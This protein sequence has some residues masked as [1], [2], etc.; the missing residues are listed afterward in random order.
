MYVEILQRRYGTSEDTPLVRIAGEAEDKPPVLIAGEYASVRAACEQN[1]SKLAHADLRGA[2][3]REANLYQAYMPQ[4]DLSGADLACANL[5]CAVLNGATLKDAKLVSASMHYTTA[6]AAELQ[7]ADMT[8][9]YCASANFQ[10]S[11]LRDVIARGTNFRS[12]LLNTAR[13]RGI[14]LSDDTTLPN[15]MAWGTYKREFVPTLLVAGGRALKDILTPKVWNCHNWDNCPMAAAFNTHGLSGVPLLYCHSASEFITYFDA[16]LL[17]LD[18]MR[19]ICGLPALEP[20][21]N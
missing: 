5:D 7:R 16:E 14:E 17:P 12:A 8:K 4:A 18:E 21:A 15:D 10:Q 2:N 1:L 6:V 3:L 9:A 13:L 20:V 11:N 19:K